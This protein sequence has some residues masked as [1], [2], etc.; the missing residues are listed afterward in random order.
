MELRTDWL[1]LIAENWR[2]DEGRQ[3]EYWR[4]EKADSVIVVAVQGDSLLLPRSSFRPG[5]KSVTPDLPGGRIAEGKTARDMIPIILNKEL[6]ISPDSLTNVVALNTEGWLINSSFSNQRLYAFA[7]EVDSRFALNETYV[8]RRV[9]KDN[10]DQLIDGL[11]C[12][13][14]RAVLMEWLRRRP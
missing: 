7:A 10:A 14:C 2:D 4:V 9:P 12:L 3:V 6:N 11:D 8:E 1:T 13:Q 5:V